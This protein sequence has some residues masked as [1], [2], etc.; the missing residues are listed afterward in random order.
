[1]LSNQ[2]SQL[3]NAEFGLGDPDIK[4]VIEEQISNNPQSEI[5]I[6]Q[7]LDTLRVA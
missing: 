5:R 2:P 1:V 4:Q 6:P 7:L 3:R